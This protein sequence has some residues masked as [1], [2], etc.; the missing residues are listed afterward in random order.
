MR[1]ELETEQNCNI[2]DPHFYGHNSISFLFSWAAQPG[3]W[4]PSLCWDMFSLQH[5]LSNY[6]ELP[7]HR[8]TLFFYTHSIQPVE[9]QGYPLDTFDRMHLLFTQVHFL[10]WQLG[11]VRGQYTTLSVLIFLVSIV[12]VYF[13]SNKHV[14]GLVGWVLWHIKHYRL[15]HAKSC[16][17]IYI[18][19]CG[20]TG[21][22]TNIEKKWT[23]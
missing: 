10:F 13:Y 17:S 6:L 8:V 7:V 21:N 18:D 3:A 23:L 1:G 19:V 12:L 5:L 11:Q 4:G 16:L 2:I 14:G 15:F 20:D 9:S 22:I